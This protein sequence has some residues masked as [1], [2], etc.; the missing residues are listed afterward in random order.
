VSASRCYAAPLLRASPTIKAADDLLVVV[1]DLSDR[2]PRKDLGILACLFDGSRILG[3]ARL[4]GDEAGV[5]EHRRPAIPTRGQQPEAMDEHDR[6][7][8]ARIRRAT[9]S[10]SR[11]TSVLDGPCDIDM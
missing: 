5:L 9:C 6:R 2:L 10:V 3:P 8:T 4:H 1:G 7:E 11:P